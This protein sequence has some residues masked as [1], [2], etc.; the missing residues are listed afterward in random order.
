M[1]DPSCPIDKISFEVGMK[2]ESPSKFTTAVKNHAVLNGFN[3]RLLM[4]SGPKIAA[5]C[6]ENCPWRI[7]ASFDCMREHFV[8][9]TLNDNHQ[10]SRAARNRHADFN[11]I[12][13]HFFDKF[14]MDLNWKVVDMM[15]EINEQF[16]I[17]VSR[18][19]CYR[20]RSAAR[21]KIQGTLNDH[22]HLLP[23]YVAELKKVNRNSTVEL[24]LDRDNPDNS[25]RFKRLY[26]C[27]ESVAR[28]FLEGCRHVIGLDGCF[29]KTE[30]KGQLLSAVGKDGNN[31]MYPI[32]WAVVEGENQ[33]SWTWFIELLMQDLGISD[34][35]GWT[36]IS[37]QQKGLENAVANLLPHGEHRNCARHIYANWKKKGHSSQL[38]KKLFWKAVKC[39]THHDFQ[40][41]M[42]QMS[43]SKPQAVQDF[44]SIGVMKF[45]RAHISEWPN[46]EVVD[47]NICECFNNYILQAR[48]KRIIDMLEDI[49]VA[50]MQ[51]FVEKKELFSNTTDEVCPRIRK[52][53]EDN[54]LQSRKCSVKHSGNYRFE[55]SEA[56]QRF[57]VDLHGKACSCRYW[58]IRGIPC[59]HAIACIHWVRQDP[60]TFVADWYKE[61]YLLAYSKGIPPMN[62]R[63]LWTATEGIYVFP[64]VVKRQPG[65]PRRN[66]RVDIS[67]MQVTGPRLSKKG[68]RVKCTLCHQVGHNRN[69]CSG[70]RIES[71]Q[72]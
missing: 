38:L 72:V 17:I 55:V 40:R 52:V 11:W 62:G 34:G 26:I 54:K 23:A 35:L 32:A 71:G 19:T 68:M 1:Y 49:R 46:C 70:R 12:T 60:D 39:T 37:D 28:G 18:Q 7:Y 4:S 43:L 6:E 51:R 15:R 33:A 47:N 69:T 44:Q 67:E 24:V 53:L 42:T 45:C 27:F 59:S 8:V 3:P 50:V 31:Q 41:V 48:S 5:V 2:F 61:L 9:K 66:R 22:Y 63:N 29:L 21:D 57:I 65:R 10:Y 64:P 30:T 25:I 14:R 36:I 13:N 56:E 20:A 58:N 16:G